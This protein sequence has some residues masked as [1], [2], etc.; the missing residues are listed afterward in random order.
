MVDHR[1]VSMVCI[2]RGARTMVDQVYVSMVREGQNGS[3][4][5]EHGRSEV[6]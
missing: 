1:Y 6:G 5:C 2:D 3:Q 4:I